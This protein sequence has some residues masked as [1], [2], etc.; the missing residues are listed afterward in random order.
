MSPPPIDGPSTPPPLPVITRDTITR[1]LESRLERA[2]RG[3]VERTAAKRGQGLREAAAFVAG[4][5]EG[6]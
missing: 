3:L 6:R 4:E 5:L 2:V 1:D